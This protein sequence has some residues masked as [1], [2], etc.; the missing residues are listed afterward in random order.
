MYRR[1]QRWML[2]IN[3][4]FLSLYDYNFLLVIEKIR[5]RNS[6][7]CGSQILLLASHHSPVWKDFS[8]Q[9]IKFKPIKDLIFWNSLFCKTPEFMDP[10]SKVIFFLVQDL[11]LAK[12]CHR[13]FHSN[14]KL[15]YWNGLWISFFLSGCYQRSLH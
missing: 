9:Q 14:W 6:K 12:D 13:H 5:K 8:L 4:R 11:K 10:L 2:I 7:I 3:N 1:S 15:L